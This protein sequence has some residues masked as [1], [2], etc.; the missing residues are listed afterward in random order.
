MGCNAVGE[1][2][3]P[4]GKIA[5][6]RDAVDVIEDNEQPAFLIFDLI[7]Q[8]QERLRECAYEMREVFLA[9]IE[10]D[11]DAKKPEFADVIAEQTLDFR[12]EILGIRFL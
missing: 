3:V 7:E 6:F 2:L 9:G 1:T 11:A 5:G 12:K 8:V 4:V 10:A